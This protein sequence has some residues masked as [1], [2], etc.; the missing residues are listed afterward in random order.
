[1][2]EGAAAGLSFRDV[3]NAL[4]IYP[5]GGGRFGGECAGRV[6]RVG[7]G[8]EK[9]A[10]GDD[11]IAVAVGGLARYVRAWAELVVPK[12]AAMSFEEAATI[13]VA[14]LTASYGL[15]DLAAI[16]PGH[17]VLIHAA[18]GGVG[19]AA[20]EV[21]R[22]AGAEV[23]ATAGSEA[24]RAYLRERGIDHVMDSR[25]LGYAAEVKERTGGKG[26]DT[27]LNSLGGEHIR[28][29]LTALVPGGS[30]V[31][32]G[33]RAIWSDEE[34]RRCRRDVKYAVL[35]LDRLVVERRSEVGEKLRS[36]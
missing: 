4:G 32:L 13:P 25:R 26:V 33:K 27:V 19:L 9:F 1:E 24:K 28:E 22:A 17:R 12:P 16:G 18:A 36:L 3:L 34:A 10:V 21:A 7:A 5:G 31:E 11:V 23:F 20:V 30:F 14:F 2:I 35:E 8:V 15:E 29:G 6:T